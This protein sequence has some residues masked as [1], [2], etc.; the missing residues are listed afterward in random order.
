MTETLT[1][2]DVERVKEL[3]RVEIDAALDILQCIFLGDSITDL[4]YDDLNDAAQALAR[5]AKRVEGMERP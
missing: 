1:P 5:A 3:A 2:K 4:T